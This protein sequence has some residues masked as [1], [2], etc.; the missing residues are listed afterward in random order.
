[1]QVNFPFLLFGRY[2]F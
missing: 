2:G 1:M